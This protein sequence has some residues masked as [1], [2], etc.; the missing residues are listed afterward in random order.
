MKRWME[1]FLS[2][3]F[4]KKYTVKTVA[5]EVRVEYRLDQKKVE[6][7][8]FAPVCVLPQNAPVRFEKSGMVMTNYLAGVEGLN[9][10]ERE[11]V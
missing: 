9:V 7:K 1:Q 11:S 4:D 10:A 6:Q 2:I 5:R 8:L 3:F